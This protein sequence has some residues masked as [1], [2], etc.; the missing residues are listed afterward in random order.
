MEMNIPWSI[1]PQ[2]ADLARACIAKTLDAGADAVRI[3]L[4]KSVMDLYSLRNGITMM[5][6]SLLTF[7]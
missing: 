5:T 3:S 2:E 1:T 6:Q 7:S 4:N